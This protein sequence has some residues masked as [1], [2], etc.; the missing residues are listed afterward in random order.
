MMTTR[1]GVGKEGLAAAALF[2]RC[3]VSLNL[4]KKKLQAGYRKIRQIPITPALYKN[5]EFRSSTLFTVLLSDFIFKF[6]LFTYC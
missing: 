4:C 2:G 3:A 5:I 6:F 1:G